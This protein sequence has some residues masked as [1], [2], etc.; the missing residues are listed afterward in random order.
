MPVRQVQEKPNKVQTSRPRGRL[1][2]LKTLFVWSAPSRLFKKRE[3]E[4]FTTAGAIAFLLAVILIFFQEWLLIA[5]IIAL[6]FMV[7]ILGTIQP[8]KVEHKITTRGIITGGKTYRWQSLEMFWFDER[9]GQKILYVETRLPFP[10]RLMMLLGETDKKE[11]R[12]LLDDYLLF[13]K[14]GKAWMDKAGDWLSNKIPLER[15]S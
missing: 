5:V 8:E 15:S 2:P 10:R 11:L 3:R 7:F 4:Y 6:G 9:L 14:P 13:E 12:Q 1:R